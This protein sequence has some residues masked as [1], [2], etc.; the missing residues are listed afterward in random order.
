MGQGTEALAPGGMKV[1]RERVFEA[2]TV[3]AAGHVSG[4]PR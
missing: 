2:R 1:E 4:D 3:A